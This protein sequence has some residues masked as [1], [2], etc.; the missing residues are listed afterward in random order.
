[1]DEV[2]D[3]VVVLEY[4]LKQGDRLLLDRIPQRACREVGY[5]VQAIK[6][7]PLLDEMLRESP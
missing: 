5:A 3:A 2:H 1:M 7:Q 6:P 4:L